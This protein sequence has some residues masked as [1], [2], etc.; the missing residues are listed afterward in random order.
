M[1]R[2]A[3]VGDIHGRIDQLRAALLA[4]DADGRHAV[5]VGDY[6]N[7]GESSA[8][9]LEEL[10]VRKARAGGRYTFLVGN[11]EL[12]LLRYLA[13]GEFAAF[14]AVGGIPTIRSYLKSAHG[15]VHGAFK[16]AFPRSHRDFLELLEPYWDDG[17]VLVSHAGFDP[18][19]PSLRSVEAMVTGARGAPFSA[20]RFPRD[21]VV[22]GHYVQSNRKPYV[23]EHLICIDTGCGS[24]QGPLT[25]AWL[26]ERTFTAA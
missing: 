23:S 2:V 25:I 26:P 19:E 10:C 17:E 5:F 7:W 14:A 24:N 16:K 13:D 21:L 6:V 3:V 18:T 1:T 12:A 9:V 20:T 22:C 15:D 8:A 11:H 4:L